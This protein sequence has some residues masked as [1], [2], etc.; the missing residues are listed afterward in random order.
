MTGNYSQLFCLTGLDF[1][2]MDGMAAK[3]T[4]LMMERTIDKI[5]T[6]NNDNYWLDTP[7]NAGAALVRWAKEHPEAIWKI[8]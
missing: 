5:G 6:N 3:D 4:I 7:G 1:R 8:T 2:S